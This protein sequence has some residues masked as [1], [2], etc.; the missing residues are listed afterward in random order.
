MDWD[1]WVYQYLQSVDA[2][3][4]IA[5]DIFVSIIKEQCIDE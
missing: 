4:S 2:L 3:Q 1:F 5:K